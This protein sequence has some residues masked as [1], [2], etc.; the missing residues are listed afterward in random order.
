MIA[1]HEMMSVPPRRLT[2]TIEHSETASSRI[3]AKNSIS[4][5]ATKWPVENSEATEAPRPRSTWSVETEASRKA[6]YIYQHRVLLLRHDSFVEQLSSFRKSVAYRTGTYHAPPHPQSSGFCQCPESPLEH[7]LKSYP[8]F[9]NQCP[10]QRCISSLGHA[11][12]CGRFS[13]PS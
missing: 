2:C 3:I 11:C 12:G 13:I 8:A 9:F 4:M 6:G 1:S 10:Q 5:R 7:V